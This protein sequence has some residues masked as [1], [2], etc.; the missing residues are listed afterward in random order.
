VLEALSVRIF[1]LWGG[2]QKDVSLMCSR[3][4]RRLRWNAHL[5]DEQPCT[6]LQT[7]LANAAGDY[8]HPRPPSCK[9]GQRCRLMRGSATAHLFTEQVAVRKWL[10]V[11][12]GCCG[13]AKAM[14]E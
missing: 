8:H 11:C 9:G 2:L 13:I 5:L 10:R 7:L 3:R 12:E 6:R 4:L 14:E 1:S